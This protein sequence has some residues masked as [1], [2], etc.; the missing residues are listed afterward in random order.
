MNWREYWDNDHPIYVS[1]R[2]KELHYRLLAR[3]MIALVP[4]P[5]AHVL[6]HGCGEAR[7]AAALA[8]ACGKLWLCDSGPN[9]RAGLSQRFGTN[10]KITVIAPETAEI[11]IPDDS[12]DLVIANSLIQYL[13][14]D[15][16]D[17]CLAL[18]RDKLKAGGILVLADVIPP[19][20]G[21]L[22][23]A[24]ALISF[25]WKGGFLIAALTGLARTA[26]SDYRKLR[27]R[28]G[29]ATYAATQMD[30]ILHDAGFA[31]VRR[32][33]NLGHNPARMTFIAQK[34]A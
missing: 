33:D 19:D 29:L 24:R 8:A 23:D 12:L 5:D 16:L 10:P 15:E 20:V 6:D 13:K 9:V 11:G 1:E 30:R 7:A 18:W 25:A 2:H 32:R 17:A 22:T 28:L 4:R 34:P 26:L 31:P 14:R 3:D 27:E 21:P